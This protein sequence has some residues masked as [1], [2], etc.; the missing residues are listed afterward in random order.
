MADGLRY[1]SRPAPRSAAGPDLDAMF[2]GAG[3]R[4]GVVTGATLRVL[5]RARS[6]RL[7]VFSFGAL[8]G[9]TRALRDAVGEGCAIRRA[10]IRRQSGR[11]ML[12]AEV[13]GT[14]EAV[15]RDLSSLGQCVFTRGGRSSGHE[16]AFAAEASNSERE[17]GWE[18]LEGQ[19]ESGEAPT[20]WRLSLESLI[21]GGGP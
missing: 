13:V 2:L 9:A 21:A 4:H 10:R 7:A 6:E 15:E 1:V 3:G 11:W 16:V 8:A 17:L 20:L 14:P 12:G 5:P 19:L 18:E